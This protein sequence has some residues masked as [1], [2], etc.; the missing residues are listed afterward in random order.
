MD[1]NEKY[2]LQDGATIGVVGGGPAGAF[3]AIRML[4]YM[5]E[6]NRSARVIIFEQ[7]H[8]LRACAGETG[9]GTYRGCPYCAGG[10]SPP[11]LDEFARLGIQLPPE[12]VQARIQLIT[13]H[14]HWKNMTVPVPA[15]RQMITVFRGRRPAR[16]PDEN[17][18]LD[19][20]LL[21]LAVQRGAEVIDATVCDAH[22]GEDGRPVFL[23]RESDSRHSVEV[24]YAVFAGGINPEPSAFMNDRPTAD[25][26]KQLLPDYETPPTRKTL[27]FEVEAAPHCETLATG[28]LHL[29]HLSSD[30]LQL[31]MCSILPKRG[32]LTVSMIGK[33][34]DAAQGPDENLRV[35][36]SF[37]A[38]HAVSPLFE[39]GAET[40]VHCICTPHIVT[41]M[42]KRPSGRRAAAIGDMAASRL[43]KDGILSAFYTAT[44][45]ARSLTHAGIDSDRLAHDYE[46]AINAFR[47]DG[48]CGRLVFFLYRAVYSRSS[49]SRILYQAFAGEI[50]WKAP[51]ARRIESLIWRI[52]S[53]DDSYA[54]ILTDM[55]RPATLWVV[56]RHGFCVTLVNILVEAAF[57]LS[58]RGIHRYPTAVRKELVL[59]R[60]RAIASDLGRRHEF[61]AWQP[62]FASTYAIMIRRPPSDTFRL[63]ARLGDPMRPWLTPR[64]VS[65][66]RVSGKPNTPGSVIRY[67][68][69]GGLLRFDI[70]LEQV[71]E[72][73]V[74]LYRVRG[75]FPDG[76]VF[77]F[78]I[79]PGTDSRLSIYLG[80]DY[81]K[82]KGAANRVFWRVFRALFPEI[83]HDVLWNHALCELKSIAEAA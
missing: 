76:G 68:I 58:W 71:L 27:I 22:Y 12:I 65:I 24:D 19:C 2:K 60:A 18:C 23:L 37:L 26:L 47:R 7:P 14:G 11:L 75:G 72:N 9:P 51:G 55:L 33:S 73:R 44:A 31:E 32:H 5:R 17:L 35:I 20:Y 77:V 13:T 78:E 66:R 82:G 52:A 80:F 40:P 53:G 70:E 29:F 41:G 63:L 38:H 49:L 74:L 34:I 67:R 39:Q 43:Y 50:K 57:G 8:R 42:A 25:I 54:D 16:R 36:H 10:L 30:D 6:L 3:F 83:I 48:A 4:S 59:D 56:F 45:L 61:D 62:D 28:E 21:D 15:D 79:Q 81:K 69:F 1:R 46:R 64:W